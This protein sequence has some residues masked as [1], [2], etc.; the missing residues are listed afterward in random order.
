MG[1]LVLF[2]FLIFPQTSRIDWVVCFY[3]FARA[4]HGGVLVYMEFLPL[5]SDGAISHLYSPQS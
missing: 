1:V 2:L 3:T 5:G 4:G